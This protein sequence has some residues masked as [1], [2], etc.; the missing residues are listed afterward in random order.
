MEEVGAPPF[1]FDLELSCPRAR[2]KTK[3]LKH[4]LD[5]DKVDRRRKCKEL[6]G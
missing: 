1:S 4:T 3:I 2:L 5:L 6:S